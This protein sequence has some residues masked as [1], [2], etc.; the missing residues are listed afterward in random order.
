MRQ[1]KGKRV[2][3]PNRIENGTLSG[4][5]AGEPFEKET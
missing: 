2:P 1:L 4:H 3:R 5:A